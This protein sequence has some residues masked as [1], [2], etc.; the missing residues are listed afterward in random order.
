V[1]FNRHQGRIADAVRTAAAELI[2]DDDRPFRPQSGERIEVMARGPR[3]AVKK[4]KRRPRSA[5]SI[6]N[7]IAPPR[8]ASRPSPVHKIGMDVL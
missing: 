3:A 5:P 6:R 7:Q 1:G 8:T 2:E 4:E